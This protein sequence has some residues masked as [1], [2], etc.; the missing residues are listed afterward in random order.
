MPPSPESSSQRSVHL[1]A[2]DREEEA[3]FFFSEI[4]LTN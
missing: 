4:S 3:L 2:L 1:G